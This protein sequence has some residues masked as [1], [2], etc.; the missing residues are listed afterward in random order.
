M[1]TDV[2][3]EINAR[4]DT[5]CTTL[6]TNG[7]SD[8]SDTRNGQNGSS[9]RIRLLVLG[10]LLLH[11]GCLGYNLYL[12]WLV[13]YLKDNN[14][15]W[16]LCFIPCLFNF[17]FPAA[18]LACHRN[19]DLNANLALLIAPSIGVS[20]N[21]IACFTMLTRQA[22]YHRQPDE[23]IGPRFIIMSLQGSIIL[24]FLEFFLQREGKLD[25]MLDYKDALTRLLLDFVDIF[26]M[27]EILSVNDCVGVGLFVSEN[28][29]TEIAVQTFCTSS[30]FIVWYTLDI[31]AVKSMYRI[32][33]FFHHAKVLKNQ[34][35]S[36]SHQ[37]HS[38]KTYR[39]VLYLGMTLMS[40]FYQNLPFLVIR[41][42]VWAHYKLYSLGFLVKNVTVIVLAIA[43]C[44]K[45]F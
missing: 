24:F 30:I 8:P 12:I 22:Y 44:F 21:L 27:V 2:D 9:R 41:I 17:V 13:A 18:Y 3:E 29:S 38:P 14:Y 25:K 23:F 20:I 11:L 39:E 28:S 31:N 6:L 15:Y 16:L 35:R 37:H 26:N 1:A 7:H 36:D 45:T 4:V 43:I 40:A 19:K 42:V 5:E 33:T 32:T 10:K 34:P